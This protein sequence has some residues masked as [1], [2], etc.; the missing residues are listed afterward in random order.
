M[1]IADGR[2][3]SRGLTVFGFRTCARDESSA[4]LS[5][6]GLGTSFACETPGLPGGRPAIPP[7]RAE[8]TAAS[9]EETGALPLARTSEQEYSR[10]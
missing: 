6:V 8:Q 5:E 7:L 1:G 10:N 9:G 3:M 2:G 4:A